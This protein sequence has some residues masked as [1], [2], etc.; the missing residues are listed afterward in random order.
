LVENDV[1]L[2]KTPPLSGEEKMMDCP[3]FVAGCWASTDKAAA[4]NAPASNG[5]L[6]FA[7][8]KYIFSL[9]H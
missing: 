5:R 1:R 3:A 9:I 2:D 8:W 4:I 6:E 7:G